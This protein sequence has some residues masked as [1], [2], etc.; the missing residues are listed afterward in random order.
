MKFLF[1]I[2][3]CLLLSPMLSKKSFPKHQ[4]RIKNYLHR[5]PVHVQVSSSSSK[6]SFDSF[7]SRNSRG[8]LLEILNKDVLANDKTGFFKEATIPNHENFEKQ[9]LLDF[10]L[11]PFCRF[12]NRSPLKRPKHMS[13]TFDITNRGTRST[14]TFTVKIEFK[15]F[16][17]TELL[18][19]D[20]HEFRN[21][22]KQLKSS[23][24]TRKNQL[25]NRR[26]WFIQKGDELYDDVKKIHN[27]DIQRHKFLDPSNPI[28]NIDNRIA[29]AI[30]SHGKVAQHYRSLRKKAQGLATHIGGLESH[31]TQLEKNRADDERALS[32]A[33]KELELSNLQMDLAKTEYHAAESSLEKLIPEARPLIRR[34]YHKGDQKD[35]QQEILKLALNS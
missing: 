14:K 10:R 3:F 26:D 2:V 35:H 25:K 24:Q 34:A 33:K 28:H 21:A 18:V 8:I 32:N 27:A 6:Y 31:S 11:I 20:A 12:T 29:A 7:I 4:L 15:G 5:K 22:L 1:F 30:Q 23:C 9:V 16:V 19:N 17:R 13:F